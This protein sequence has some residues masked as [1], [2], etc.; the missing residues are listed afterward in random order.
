M[1]NYNF[2]GLVSSGV[3]SKPPGQ[4]MSTYLSSLPN[5]ACS[6][7]ASTAPAAAGNG[8]AADASGS[9][10]GSGSEVDEGNGNPT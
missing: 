6:L 8:T 2:Q 9:G 1:A 4:T 10:S 7:A 5:N 3:I